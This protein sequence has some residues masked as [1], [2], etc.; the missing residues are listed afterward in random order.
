MSADDVFLSVEEFSVRLQ[1]LRA[2]RRKKKLVLRSSLRRRV[3]LTRVDR[4][5]ILEKAG[6]RC[7]ICGGEIYGAWEA[8]HV[9]S[10]CL[11]GQHAISNY[12]PAHPI[13]NNYRWFY[14]PEEFQWILKLGVWLRTKIELKQRIGLEAASQFIRSDNL[15]AKRRRLNK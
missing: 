9:Y 10:H 5:A 1:S 7:H 12:L 8:D 2:S 14:G 6:G 11:G 4:D 13:C 15:R 3:S